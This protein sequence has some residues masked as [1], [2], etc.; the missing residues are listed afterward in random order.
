LVAPSKRRLMSPSEQ[1]ARIGPRT[2]T[3]LSD[4]IRHGFSFPSLVTLRRVQFAQKWV[5]LAA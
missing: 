5:L 4:L 2:S 1:P 3:R